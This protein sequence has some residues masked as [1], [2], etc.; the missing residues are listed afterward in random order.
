MFHSPSQRNVSISV[1]R[2]ISHRA[3]GSRS[4]PFES[5]KSAE[6]GAH[7]SRRRSVGSLADREVRGPERLGAR[8]SW[9]ANPDERLPSLLTQPGRRWEGRSKIGSIVT[10]EAGS[11][12][13]WPR[14]SETSAV[15][16]VLIEDDGRFSSPTPRPAS[17]LSRPQS[18]WSE[19][20]PRRLGSAPSKTAVDLLAAQHGGR[21]RRCARQSGLSGQMHGATLLDAADRPLRPGDL[22]ERWAFFSAK[23][24]SSMPTRAF[25]ALTGKHR[26]FRASPRQSSSGW[27]VTNPISLPWYAGCCCP[28]T[29]CGCGCRAIM[30]RICRI[31]AGTAWLDVARRQWSGEL[32]QATGLAERQMPALFEGTQATGRL[33]PALAARWGM[34]NHRRHRRRGGRQTRR[35]PCGVGT[36]APGSGLRLAGN[37]GRLVHHDRKLPAQRR[38]RRPYVSA[39]H[40]P[41][42]GI[43][44]G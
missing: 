15:K 36:V 18:G 7:S 16:A 12:A 44:W 28:R 27:R 2:A 41:P 21:A 35:P 11:H 6:A 38:Q 14:Q 34:A 1:T 29:T 13:A 33:R 20:D 26:L 40:C 17:A 9:S 25:R 22:V 43:R 37:L 10:D 19:Q 3:R 42:P 4:K 8:T 5:L 23:P 31:R 24:R 32:L 39:T 30:R